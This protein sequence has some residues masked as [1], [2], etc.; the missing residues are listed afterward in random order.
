[1]CPPFR[2]ST[3]QTA[4]YLSPQICNGESYGK[5][6]DLWACGVVGYV[7]LAGKFP[8][9]G[10]T[11]EKFMS[12]MRDGVKFPD[13]EW[14][15]VSR[16]AKSLLRGLLDP[17]PETRL[18][19]EQALAHRWLASDD[20]LAPS[21]SMSVTRPHMT[22]AD[23]RI[24]DEL[25][26]AA[27]NESLSLQLSVFAPSANRRRALLNGA[28]LAEDN[29]EDV[30]LRTEELEHHAAE[31]D[32]DDSLLDEAADYPYGRHASK[33]FDY[34]YGMDEESDDDADA[35]GSAIHEAP[36]HV[37]PPIATIRARPAEV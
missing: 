5:S 33:A 4:F 1:V 22:V 21:T 3:P 35:A 10:D 19:A 9:Y 8:F 31:T 20:S 32:G 13:K 6:V 24:L 29:A 15:N 18:T 23:A 12:R 34:Y 26:H 2:D 25:Q 36:I 37:D 16:A 30:V 14:R 7:M 17:N 28:D 11:D 27:K